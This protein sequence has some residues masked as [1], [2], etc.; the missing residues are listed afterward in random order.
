MLRQSAQHPLSVFSQF[1]SLGLSCKVQ[2]EIIELSAVPSETV[3]LPILSAANIRIGDN[4]LQ[5]SFWGKLTTIF[6]PLFKL[7]LFLGL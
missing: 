6:D 2:F 5:V 3:A 1:T 4:L 7:S